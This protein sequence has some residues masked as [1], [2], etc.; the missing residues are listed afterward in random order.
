V[1]RSSRRPSTFG[2]VDILVVARHHRD[3]AAQD[4]RVRLRCRRRRP[5]KGT[6]NCAAPGDEAKEYG[7]IN[8]VVG[9]AA[10]NFGQTNCGAAKAS[11]MG[12]TFVVDGAAATAS[13]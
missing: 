7:R 13:P 1:P 4:G 2:T 8:I 5:L 9:R 6:F 12:M 11:I 10:N 3:R